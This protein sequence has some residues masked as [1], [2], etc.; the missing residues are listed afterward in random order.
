MRAIKIKIV[1]E[2]IKSF[3]IIGKLFSKDITTILNASIY[4]ILIALKALKF[5]SVFL[6]ITAYTAI[7]IAKKS[8]QFQKSLRYAPS[9]N[10]IPNTISLSV[11]STANKL[12]ITISMVVMALLMELFG[13]KVG[14]SKIMTRQDRR[15][16]ARIK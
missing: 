15:I 6:N 1:I 4:K 8:M 12:L 5:P 3:M 9:G 14:S 13:S 10:I 7:T 16:R 2:R 11:S